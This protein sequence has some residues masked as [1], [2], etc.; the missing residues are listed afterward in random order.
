MTD[1]EIIKGLECCIGYHECSKCPYN[2][3]A[4]GTS[5]CMSECTRDALDLINRQKAEIESLI[6]NVKKC[7]IRNKT[8]SRYFKVLSDQPILIYP[9]NEASIEIIPSKETIRAEAIK[10]FAERLK[11]TLIINNEENTEIFD[12]DYT[13]ETIDNLVKEMIGEQE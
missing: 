8:P 4:A 11:E 1:K 7:F 3:G 10:D 9:Y 6:G 2:S 13:L 12:Y 5:E